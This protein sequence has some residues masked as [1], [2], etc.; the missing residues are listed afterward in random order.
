MLAVVSNS[1]VPLVCHIS[2]IL[3]HTSKLKVKSVHV[4][5]S[6]YNQYCYMKYQVSLDIHTSLLENTPL[7]TLFVH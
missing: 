5:D 4:G 6:C 1:A 2:R 3:V 7:L